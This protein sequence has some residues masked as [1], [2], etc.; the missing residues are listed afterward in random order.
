MFLGFGAATVAAMGS[1][2]RQLGEGLLYPWHCGN[3]PSPAGVAAAL[4]AVVLS[5]GLLV[6]LVRSRS[7]PLWM[8][9]AMLVAFIGAL[10]GQD[11][12]ITRR[13]VPGANLAMLQLGQALQQ[14]MRSHL[15]DHQRVPADAAAWEAALAAVLAENPTLESPYRRRYFSRVPWSIVGLAQ[16]G[17][18]NPAAPP[19]AFAIWLPPDASRFTIT[20][21]GLAVDHQVV[22]LRDAEGQIVD[23]KGAFTPDTRQ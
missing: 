17:D 10:L 18:F 15:Q 11:L 6:F 14:K 3:P 20:L 19:G 8:S 13:S 12:P 23:L 4:V 1:E 21:C 9:V 7:A 5:L 22:R 2:L 16:E